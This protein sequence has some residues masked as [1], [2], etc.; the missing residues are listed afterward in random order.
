MYE[1][2]SPSN[3]H[4]TCDGMNNSVLRK[5]KLALSDEDQVIFNEIMPSNNEDYHP[6]HFST[7]SFFTQ[8][9]IEC[10]KRKMNGGQNVIGIYNIAEARNYLDTD[11]THWK[12][13]TEEVISN[14][15]L[16]FSLQMQGWRFLRRTHPT[17]V[18]IMKISR[19]RMRVTNDPS[20]KMNEEEI[21]NSTGYMALLKSEYRKMQ[22]YKM[23]MQ[24][25]S[26]ANQVSRKQ[27][28]NNNENDMSV[29]VDKY[30]S[31]LNKEF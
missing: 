11:F 27:N 9:N 15:H 14:L 24:S 8:L 23:N 13:D 6:L 18:D 10:K 2:A 30:L 17:N 5:T 21:S 29:E 3:T 20:Y 31:A 28:Q 19:T 4:M 12:I 1:H 7:G 22:L 25:Q 26:Q 16:I